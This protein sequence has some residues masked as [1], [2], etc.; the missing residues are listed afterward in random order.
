MTLRDAATTPTSAAPAVPAETLGDR[1]F[2]AALGTIDVQ[3]VYL[4]DRL[5]YYRQLAE[6][7]PMTPS[8][9]AARAGTVERYTREW[10]EQQATTGLLVVTAP[11]DPAGE[12][13]FALPPEHAATFTDEESLEFFPPFAR[14]LVAA[15]VQLPAVLAA[16]RTGG[17]VSWDQFGDEMRWA[18]GDMN[19]PFFVGPLGS[20]WFP[21]VPEIHDRLRAGGRVADVGCGHGWASIGLARAYPGI[22]VD[23][24]DVDGPSVDAATE[25]AAAAGLADRVRFVL[26]DLADVPGTG[27]D[28]VTA[29]ECIH[30]MP[31][32]VTVLTSMRAMAAPGGVVVVMDEKV[33]PEFGAIGDGV[34][35]VMYG[36]SN[37]VCLPDSMAHQGSVATGTVIRESVMR[38]Y[39]ERAGFEKVEV[40]PIEAD[41]WRCYRLA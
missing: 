30:D 15:A 33:A 25:H 23:G 26:S 32:P 39:A 21:A 2:S 34:E 29:F 9:L 11:A 35:R 41:L 20:E 10:L 3:T 12:R 1:L 38:G 8:E 28:V 18:Q 14:M 19:R 27:Y 13:R 40:L 7:G 16:H 36:F 17:G 6:H 22:R 31:D 5:G 4:G 24:Y 37:L